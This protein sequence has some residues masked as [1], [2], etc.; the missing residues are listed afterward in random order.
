MAM[1]GAVE[2]VHVTRQRRARA[3]RQQADHELLMGL[4][5]LAA[6]SVGVQRALIEAGAALFEWC[7]LRAGHSGKPVPKG[8]KLAI[9]GN[10]CGPGHGGGPCIDMADCL[11]K[12]HDL[13]YAYA[14][15]VASGRFA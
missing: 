12:R 8:L 4:R 15:G 2:W 1:L 9:Y 14:A 3:I 11:C 6:R 13:A 5:R 7:W 10:W